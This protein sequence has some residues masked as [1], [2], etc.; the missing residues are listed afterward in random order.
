MEQSSIQQ[1]ISGIRTVNR[2]RCSEVPQAITGD[3]SPCYWQRKEWIDWILELADSAEA[4]INKPNPVE[5]DRQTYGDL[6]SV[7]RYMAGCNGFS[8][9][10]LEQWPADTGFDLSELDQLAARLTDPEEI[11]MFT[12]GEEAEVSAIAEKYDI[13][14]LNDFLNEV[15][16]GRLHNQISISADD[17][18]PVVHCWD[19]DDS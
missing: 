15:F 7:T 13:Q 4:E 1:L 18:Q 12:D 10:P 17:E 5:A 8:I 9:K 3:E 16:D 14:Q 6:I 2:G 19:G 11:S